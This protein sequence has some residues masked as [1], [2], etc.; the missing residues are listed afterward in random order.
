MPLYCYIVVTGMY[1]DVEAHIL[2]HTN[3]YSQDEFDNIC[4]KLT[5]KY[6]DVEE[7]EYF[8]SYDTSNVKQIKYNI[9]SYRLI[10]LLIR[11]YGFIEL[12]VPIND[13]YNTK[14][15]SRTKVPP[16]RLQK[17]V[18][19]QINACPMIDDS[20]IWDDVESDFIGGFHPNA[21]CT[22]VKKEKDQ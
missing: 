18:V 17:V 5:E 16:E 14:E 2:G 22:L 11:D 10:R 8:S 7:I 3:K 13:G 19:K 20:L 1:E 15:I 4:I 21:R 6:G 12:D 9:D